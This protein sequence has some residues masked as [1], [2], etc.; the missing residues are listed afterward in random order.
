MDWDDI[1]LF[2]ALLR[3]GNVRSAAAR[4]GVSHSTVA[5]RIDALESQLRVRLFERLP[6][7]YVLTPTGEDML[8]T[9]ERVEDELG[10]L[11]RRIVGQ[12]SR[13]EGPIRVSMIDAFATHLLMPDLASFAVLYPDIELQIPVSY[14]TVDLDRREADVAVRFSKSPP[15]H[16]IG[17]RLSGCAMAPYAAHDYLADRDVDDP[18]GG[19]WIGFTSQGRYRDWVKQSAFPK[20][21][22]R[23]EFVSLL[24]QVAAC[25]SG[26]GLAMLPRF[27]GD[28]ETDLVRVGASTIDP[29]L[30]VWILTHRDVR[31]SARIRAFSSFLGDAIIAKR[32][33]L[34]GM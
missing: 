26:M 32:N 10:G 6:S 31:S 2:L 29:R 18:A 13:L 22:V 9:A 23:G 28:V 14:E 1:K 34:E 27:I 19:V 3:G 11:E 21:P 24:T 25:K 33:L 15:D 20:F 4:L 17:R 8:K 30:D 5:R 16:L 7:G 12:D